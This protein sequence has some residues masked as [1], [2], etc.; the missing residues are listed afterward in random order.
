MSYLVGSNEAQLRAKLKYMIRGAKVRSL[1]IDLPGWDVDLIGPSN[2]VN[3]DAVAMGQNSP[4]V[5]PLLQAHSGELELTFEGRQEISP[6]SGKVSLRMP[7]PRGQSVAPANV[8]ILPADNVELLIE[9]DETSSLVA[10]NV[11]AKGIQLPDRQQEPLYLR[12]SGDSPTFVAS[13]LVHEQT[14]STAVSAQL[15]VDERETRVDERM[16]VQIAYEPTDHLTLGVPR[17]I[18]ADRLTITLDGQRLT[19]VPTRERADKATSDVVPMRIALPTPRVGRIEL[20]IR[21]SLPHDQ[22]A[23]LANTLVTVPLVMPGEGPLASNEL[24]VVPKSGISVSYP[25][26]PWTEAPRGDRSNNT[27][28][29]ILTAT[30]ALPQVALAVSFKERHL[31]HATTVEQAWIQTRLTETQRQ[32]RAV[33]RLTTSEPSLRLSM[34]AGLESA[35]LVVEIDGRRIKPELDLRDDTRDLVVP[36]SVRAAGEHL[37]DLRYHFSDRPRAVSWRSKRSNSSRRGGSSRRIGSWSCPPASTCLEFPRILP[38]SI[39]GFGRICSGFAIR[40]STSASSRVGSRP[41]DRA[42]PPA[43]LEKPT[44]SSRHANR[45]KP[46]R[47]TTICIS[48]VGAVQ[49]LEVYTLGRARLVLF[50]SLPI[51]MCGLLLI[52]LPAT[53]HP[54]ALLIA[55]VGLAVAGIIDPESAVLLAQAASLGLVLALVAFILTRIWQRPEP[56]P[57]SSHGSSKAIERPFTEIYPR[58]VGSGS[59]PSTTTNPLVPSS[60]PESQP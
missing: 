10:Q 3:V 20:Q 60:V 36:I 15:D 11:R 43:S 44:S 55:A 6:A 58:A 56:P 25:K 19:P 4:L 1:E 50:A 46:A 51:L 24:S 21:Y 42:T 54:A 59:Q 31:Q 45:P 13:I 5:I 29:L 41:R 47:A 30:S 2:L 17:A 32:D 48:A 38:A 49:P 37:L 52:Y 40:R 39:A 33:Y 12:T 53:R 35:S 9:P 28:G 23:S 26:G 57:A 8:I 14:M 22:L 16:T 34:P 27:A 7:A 18:R